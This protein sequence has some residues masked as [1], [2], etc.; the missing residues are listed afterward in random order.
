VGGEEGGRGKEGAEEGRLPI[1]YTQ[2]P[3]T[4]NQWVI[5]GKSSID[6][7]D[8]KNGR[9]EVVAVE[10]TAFFTLSQANAALPLSKAI[11]SKLP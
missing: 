9:K 4:I 3:F 11:Q 8:G 2:S 7:M 5:L 10:L 6:V 1:V